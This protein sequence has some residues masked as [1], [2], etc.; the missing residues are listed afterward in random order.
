MTTA[1][2]LFIA[3]QSPEADTGRLEEALSDWKLEY[4]ASHAVY[5]MAQ[6]AVRRRVRAAAALGSLDQERRGVHG[7]QRHGVRTCAPDM[8]R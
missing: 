5:L 2:F 7:M 6:L 4:G 1:L 3:L 8:A